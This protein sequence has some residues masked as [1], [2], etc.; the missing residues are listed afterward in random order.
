M[1]SRKIIV[2]DPGF[3]GKDKINEVQPKENPHS[4]NWQNGIT[5]NS[6]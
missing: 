6:I 5:R 2:I 3:A 4:G 1:N